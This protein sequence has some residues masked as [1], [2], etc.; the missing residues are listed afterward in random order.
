MYET[1][2]FEELTAPQA[3]VYFALIVGALFGILAERT[4][5]CLRRSLIGTDRRAASGVWL[6]ALAVALLGTQASVYAGW[7]TFDEHRF[8]VSDLPIAAIVIGGLMFGSGMVLTRGC[9]SRLTVL[10]AT[11]NLRA[12]TVLVIFAITA[13]ALLKGVLAPVR[14]TLGSVTV[15]LGE[16]TS[17]AAL[18]GGALVWSALIALLA[19]GLALRSGNRVSTLVQAAVL[20][21]LVP[22]AWVGT[23]FILYDDFDPIALQGLAFT[24]TWA[25][26]L[27]W[28]IAS[29][30]IPAGFGTGLV[31]GV[32]IGSFLSAAA[33]K[34]LSWTSFTSPRETGRY[35]TGALLM[36]A[37][38]TLAG[39]CTVGAGLAGIPTLG[40]AAILA[41]AAIATGALT[42]NALLQAG[43]SNATLHPAE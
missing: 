37:G 9:A 29:T 40:T 5:F 38:G 13:H 31:G 33:S 20:G 6:T 32:L 11:G 43:Q 18:P 24:S 17:L 26:S 10:A 7:I 8:L 16:A 19:L 39:G 2:G 3:A 27:F 42:L 28:T 12:L 30:S 36:G 23:G 4:K 1:F 14:T 21:A 25:D 22:L 35:M 34:R 41:T 15:Q